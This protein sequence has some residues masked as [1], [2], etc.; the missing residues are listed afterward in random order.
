MLR[1]DPDQEGEGN[2]NQRLQVA[3]SI[4]LGAAVVC[5]GAGPGLADHYK[6]ITR[7]H[8]YSGVS[9]FNYLDIPGGRCAFD[10]TTGDLIGCQGF[11]LTLMNPVHDTQAVATL[12]YTN[13]RTASRQPDDPNAGLGTE[14]FLGCRVDKLTPH[15]SIAIDWS[16]IP[17]AEDVGIIQR[18]VPDRYAEVIWAPLTPV[19]VPVAGGGTGF[20][21]LANGLGGRA[22]AMSRGFLTTLSRRSDTGDIAHPKMLSL[23]DN[24]VVPGQKAAALICVCGAV[25]DQ[26][27]DPSTFRP[28]SLGCDPMP[29]KPPVSSETPAVKARTR[30]SR[31]MSSRTGT[32][33]SA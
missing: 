10:E 29:N 23:P 7:S 26:G 8:I 15:A 30:Q 18:V 14:I 31:L 1:E 3:A 33:S 17:G 22:R 11:D 19:P 27:L 13:S 21:R 5:C 24:D 6:N 9:Q 20:R 4:V 16:E 25:I 2:M 12:V 28:F 32:G